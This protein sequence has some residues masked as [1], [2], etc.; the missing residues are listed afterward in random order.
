MARVTNPLTNTEVDKA[1]AQAKVSSLFDGDGLELKITPT[2]TKKWLFK[3]YKPFTKKRTNLTF[4]EYPDISLADA[5]KLRAKAKELL[6]K[7]IDPK[8]HKDN[9]SRQQHGKIIIN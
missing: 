1:K 2:G 8:E 4:G 6:A 7:D 3:Y 9:L 5:R